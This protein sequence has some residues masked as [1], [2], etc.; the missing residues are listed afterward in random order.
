ML[1]SEAGA[2]KLNFNEVGKKT[3]SIQLR[4]DK[5][6][7]LRRQSLK[8]YKKLLENSR[9]LRSCHGCYKIVEFPTTSVKR[10]KIYMNIHNYSAKIFKTTLTYKEFY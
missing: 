5:L 2:F 6:Y 4:T 10:H 3:H 9:K 7:E 1:S 8:I